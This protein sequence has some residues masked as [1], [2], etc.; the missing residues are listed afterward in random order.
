MVFSSVIFLFVF[1]P[2]FLLIYYLIPS[3]KTYLYKNIVLLMFSLLFYSFGEPIYILLMIFSSVVDYINGFMINKYSDKK[4]LKKLFL[5]LS[6]IINLSLL[7]FFKYSDFLINNINSIFDLSLNNLNIPLPIGISFFTFQTM[8]YSIDVYLG[9]VKYEKKF[10]NFMTY[11]CMFP[12]LIAGPIVRYETVSEELHNRSITYT[13]FNQ[14]LIRFMFGLFKKVLIANNVGLLFKDISVLSQTELSF[15]LAWLGI[16]AYALQIYFDFSGYSDMA[17]GMGKMLGFTYEENFNYPYISKSITDF[18]RRWH[19][20]LSGFFKDYVYIPLGGSKTTRLKNV[21]NILVVWSLT[22]LW[23][24]A[25]WNFILWGLYF[26]IILIIEKFLLKN[27]LS[28]MPNLFK[29]IYAILL[30]LIGWALF[31][32]SD[33]VYSKDYFFS[34][35]GIN[36]VFVNKKFVYYLINYGFVLIVGI[37]LSIPIY[38]YL[39]KKLNSINN[40]VLEFILFIFIVIIFII[41][42]VI[43]ISYLVSSTYN[44]FLYFRF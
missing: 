42:F 32:L 24:G 13:K 17:I 16:V 39:N 36:T 6:I 27:I 5:I 44:P 21:R 12:Q 18:W 33:I 8:S 31:S 14:G 37:I 40:R 35:M 3:K 29:H 11:V 15:L 2:I 43:T 28:K 41:L 25:N 34:L 26:G 9:R 4:I 23:H 30:I 1:L 10:L 22:G 38:P 19:M 20:S 7:G